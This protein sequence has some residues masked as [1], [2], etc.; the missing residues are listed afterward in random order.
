M[1][2]KKFLSTPARKNHFTGP[3]TA[4]L[5]LLLGGGGQRS[6]QWGRRSIFQQIQTRNKKSGLETNN[7][8]SWRPVSSLYSQCEKGRWSA[9]WRSRP[10]LSTR[11]QTSYLRIVSYGSTPS[12][13]L[14]LSAWCWISGELPFGNKD[15][16]STKVFP[17]RL[18]S[19]DFMRCLPCHIY[20]F[21]LN[22]N[23]VSS[24]L[25]RLLLSCSPE[26]FSSILQR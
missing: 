2:K 7:T 24:S 3:K 18:H 26:P 1:K 22:M 6:E 16:H 12:L 13:F 14:K 9:Y 23:L 21:Q 25:S 5:C 17:C 8:A 20:W 10:C 19:K 15:L 11:I 4:K